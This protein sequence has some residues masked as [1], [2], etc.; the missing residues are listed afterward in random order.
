MG[1][2]VPPLAVDSPSYCTKDI[3]YRFGLQC[4]FSCHFFVS[5]MK[6][7]IEPLSPVQKKLVFEIPPERVREEIEKAYRTF[8]H[9]ARVKGF[10]AGKAPRPLLE[11][12]FGE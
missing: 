4:S 6:I 1:V 12:H 5:L 10:R 9:S 3:P 2:Q 8:Q 11:R 7:T